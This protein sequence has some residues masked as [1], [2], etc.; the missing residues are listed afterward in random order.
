MEF[1]KLSRVK[2]IIVGIMMIYVSGCSLV[3]PFVDRRRDAGQTGDKLYVGRSQ[4]EAPV[5]CYN[6]WATEFEEVQK[7]ADEECLKH[8]V[9]IKA[10]FV[11]EEKF[12]C[13]LLTPIYSNFKCVKE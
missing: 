4:P 8:N 3:Q 12:S 5:I 13:R 1:L 6:S 10:E 2:L 11:D 9:G 7:I